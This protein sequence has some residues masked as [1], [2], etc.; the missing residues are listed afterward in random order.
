MKNDSL[1]KKLTADSVLECQHHCAQND[2]CQ[3]F[4]W[5]SRAKNCFLRSNLV[6][7][8]ASFTHFTESNVGARDCSNIK[9]I[10]PEIYPHPRAQP[11]METHHPETSFATTNSPE[12]M[13]E[14]PNQAETD[15]M[16]SRLP[17]DADINPSSGTRR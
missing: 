12:S 8:A 7:G 6:N 17:S 2:E 14:Q 5:N 10:W 11:Q 3:Y 13:S 9:I 16:S 15:P 1:I 4:S